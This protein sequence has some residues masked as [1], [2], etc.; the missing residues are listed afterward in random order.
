MVSRER[1]IS[2]IRSEKI[3]SILRGIPNDKLIRTIEA[4]HKGGISCVEI[5][6]NHSTQESYRETLDAIALARKHFGNDCMLGAGTVVNEDDVIAANN[7]G[8]RFIVS[9]NTDE[10]SIRKTRELM[11]VSLPGAYTPSEICNAYAWGADFVKVFPLE[12]STAAS[13]MTALNGPLAYIPKIAVAGVSLE[14]LE[15]VMK[16]GAVGIGI[17]KNIAGAFVKD[18][19]TDADFEKIT[20]NAAKYI[21]VLKNF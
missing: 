2:T 6:L 21:S 17:G 7:A 9:P 11:M 5:T 13:Y 4:I 20:E 12:K 1:I 14:N 18:Y 10:R 3:V 16:A 15:E 8:A 19:N